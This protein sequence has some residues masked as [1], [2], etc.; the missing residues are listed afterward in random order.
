MHWMLID[1]APRVLPE[2]DKQLWPCADW[3]SEQRPPVSAVSKVT[4]RDVQLDLPK[5]S[6]YL[7]LVGTVLSTPWIRRAPTRLL[8][9]A[10]R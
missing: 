1:L 2:L 7:L 9:R 3:Q 5:S 10:F 8:E 4:G 6:D